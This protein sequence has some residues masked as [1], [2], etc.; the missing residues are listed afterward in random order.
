MLIVKK[1]KKNKKVKRKRKRKEKRKKEKRNTFT[2]LQAC[3]LG[4]VRVIG[5]NSLGDSH[6]QTNVI[7]DVGNLF[8][9]YLHITYFVLCTLTSY[10]HYTQI[11]AKV[12]T[13]DC[14][15]TNLAIFNCIW[16]DV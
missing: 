3:F 16:I 15:L 11:F 8:N 4:D 14:V 9:Y 7:D 10:T 12:Y 13:Y 5:Y 1:E 2:W 6:F